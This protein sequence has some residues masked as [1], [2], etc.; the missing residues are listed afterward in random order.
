MLGDMR[1]NFDLLEDVCD[2]LERAINDEPPALLRDGNVI[3]EGFN[4]E[5]DNLRIAM[6]DGKSGL[7]HLK[8]KNVN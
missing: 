8:T 6:R 4:E 2:L 7:R 1:K 3:K 5:I